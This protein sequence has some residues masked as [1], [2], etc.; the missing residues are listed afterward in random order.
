V[1]WALAGVSIAYG[2]ALVVAR[3]THRTLA[4]AA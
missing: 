4:D 2:L 3:A 1:D